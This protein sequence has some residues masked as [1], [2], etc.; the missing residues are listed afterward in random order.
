M[1]ECGRCECE[2]MNWNEQECPY[3]VDLGRFVLNQAQYQEYNYGSASYY[4]EANRD[5]KNY[6]EDSVPQF[7]N[8]QMQGK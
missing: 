8:F 5:S 7:T 6:E 3:T 1:F 4:N 2:E